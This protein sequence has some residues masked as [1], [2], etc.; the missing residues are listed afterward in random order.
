MPKSKLAV[1]DGLDLRT[2]PKRRHAVTLIITAL[3]LIRN[4]EEAYQ[5]RIPANF[6]DGDAYAASEESVCFLNDAIEFLTDAF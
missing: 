2:R 3:E 1:I 5:G 4:E 6:R